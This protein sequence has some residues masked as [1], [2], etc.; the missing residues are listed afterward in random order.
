MKKLLLLATLMV[1]VN[2]A[3]AQTAI[4]TTD[5]NATAARIRWWREA[6][7]GMFIHYG[8]V[9]LT[10][11]EISWSRANSN[12][13]CPNHGPTPVAV[14]DNLY[15]EFNPTNFNAA[16]WAGV[17]K[18][19]GMKY[20]VLTAKHCDGFLLWDSKVDGYN[21]TATPFQRDLCAEL[22]RAARQDGLRIGWYFS[23]MDWRDPDFRTER[24]GDYLKR[25]QGEIRELLSNYG[26]IDL[27]W[28]DFD[29]REAV[30]DQTN[31]YA[32][33]KKLQPEI[34]IDNRLDLGVNQSNRRILNPNA[35]YYT[36]EQQIGAY[37]DQRPWETCMTI[38]Q[39][40][41]W[42]P[43]DKLKSPAE[44]VSILCRVVGGDG[45]LLLN[46]GPMPDGRI[47]PRQVEVLKQVGA[48]MEVNGESIYATR[49]GPWKPTPAL[50]STRKGSVVYV[51]VL[52]ADGDRIELSALPRKIESASVLGGGKIETETADGKFILHLPAKRD[53]L[54]TVIKLN[55]AGSAMDIPVLAAG[56]KTD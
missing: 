37:D 25:M 52:K 39:Q 41:A 49:G 54:A 6:R 28:F 53:P 23:P 29:G 24:N 17:A 22:S 5:A 18:M 35:D 30:Y 2:V 7:F 19:A 55:L 4:V 16:D 36:P 9:T 46:V 10:G 12:P 48:W 26:R 51:H 44:V 38:C 13:K 42:K 34:I 56:P 20:M 21:I 8:P 27:L 32:L 33:V 47:E 1:V 11:K 43:N 40:W 50:T 15:K 31:T 14:Y 45:N 3:L